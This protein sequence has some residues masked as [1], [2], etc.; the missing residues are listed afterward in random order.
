VRTPYFVKARPKRGR[1][2]RGPNGREAHLGLKVRGFIGRCS[3]RLVS[4]VVQRT[5]LCPSLEVA[6]Q[7]LARRGIAM[8]VKTL[9]RLCRE[10]GE[11]GL[12][13]RSAISLSGTEE[14]AGQT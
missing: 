9:R 4:E 6:H 10:L 7:G 2:K 11:R 5:V 1:K 12:G 14:L 13:H 8:D 3:A